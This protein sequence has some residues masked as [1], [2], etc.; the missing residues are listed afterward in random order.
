MGEWAG[1]RTRRAVVSTPTRSWPWRPFSSSGLGW[2]SPPGRAVCISG[3]GA[4]RSSCRPGFRLGATPSAGRS[5]QPRVPGLAHPRERATRRR[6]AALARGPLALTLEVREARGPYGSPARRR[7]ATRRRP[8]AFARPRRRRCGRRR[9][10]ARPRVP[11]PL[12]PCP[13]HG[14]SDLDPSPIRACRRDRRWHRDRPRSLSAPP[15]P[16]HRNRAGLRPCP[17]LASRP[18]P[19]QVP[20]AVGRVRH[21]PGGRCHRSHPARRDR[22][23]IRG[24]RSNRVPRLHRVATRRDLER[25]QH[26]H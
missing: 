9:R 18:L 2:G 5:R 21:H 25:R 22:G 12:R 26:R 11:P 7:A 20:P 6:R 24:C 16:R 8:R 13:P 17:T 23:S 3:G 1:C 14:R 4:A 19:G 15:L 10:P